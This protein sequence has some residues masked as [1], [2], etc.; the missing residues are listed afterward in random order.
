MREAYIPY[1]PVEIKIEMPSSFVVT[2]TL[3]LIF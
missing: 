1:Y 2:D 3:M